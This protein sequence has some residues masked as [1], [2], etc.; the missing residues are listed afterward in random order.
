MEVK[1]LRK[2]AGTWNEKGQ[3]QFTRMAVKCEYDLSMVTPAVKKKVIEALRTGVLGSTGGLAAMV[4]RVMSD[5]FEL[6]Y[7][8]ASCTGQQLYTNF[9]N[10]EFYDALV[11]TYNLT[12]N[13]N[14]DRYVHR[15][16]R[17]IHCHSWNAQDAITR[18]L[19]ADTIGYEDKEVRE[20]AIDF[21][22]EGGKFTQTWID[23]NPI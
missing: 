22:S 15:Y 9:V 2:I 10:D 20:K 14:G 17:N 18:N 7:V 11:A 3:S 13:G 12:H 19:Y 23:K 8:C 6:K 4:Y 1:T 16:A 21:L 5:A